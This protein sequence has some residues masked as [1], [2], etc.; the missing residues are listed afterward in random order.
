MNRRRLLIVASM[1]A[2]VAVA[3]ALFAWK[4]GHEAEG[5]V[6]ARIVLRAGPKP[7]EGAPTP[8]RLVGEWPGSTQSHVTTRE[9]LHIEYAGLRTPAYAVVV[10]IDQAGGEHQYLPRPDAEPTQAVATEDPRPLGPGVPL[11][12]QR[13][14]EFRVFAVFSEQPL[15]ARAVRD[16][17]DR[18]SAAGRPGKLQGLQAG[19]I[20]GVL[21]IDP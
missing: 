4:G 11:G 10:A 15:D 2:V 16:A 5:P 13:P 3:L 18:A 14:G 9:L 19:Y 7:E 6:P 20:T 17:A 21:T 12:R 8:L 1:V